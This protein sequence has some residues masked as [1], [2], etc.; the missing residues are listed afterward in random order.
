RW[1]E[2]QINALAALA[3]LYAGRR[4][5]VRAVESIQQVL[6]LDRLRETAYRDLMHYSLLRGDRQTAIRAFRTCEQ[7]LREELGVAP[8]P[9]TAALHE[10]ARAPA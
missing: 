5:Y 10:Q 4:D 6:A 7:L 9:E 2:A 8:Q 1:R 3:R